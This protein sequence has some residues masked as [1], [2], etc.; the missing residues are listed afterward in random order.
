MDPVTG[1]LGGILAAF[2]LSGAAGL[3]AWL[4]L[5]AAGFIGLALASVLFLWLPF[6]ELA[7]TRHSDPDR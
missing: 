1:T 6:A 7:R 2:G 4:P 5:L 3:N